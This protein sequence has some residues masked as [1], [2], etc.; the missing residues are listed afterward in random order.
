MMIPIETEFDRLFRLT[1]KEELAKN[2]RLKKKM[3]QIR[4]TI[5]DLKLMELKQKYLRCKPLLLR[6]IT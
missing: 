6:E 3:L 2:T 1:S 5:E 4:Q